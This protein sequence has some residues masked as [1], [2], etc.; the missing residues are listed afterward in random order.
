MEHR[1]VNFK[2]AW[3][4][5]L[6]CSK[7]WIWNDMKFGLIQHTEE[8]RFEVTSIFWEVDGPVRLGWLGGWW[9]ER[10]QP[11]CAH[12]P[13]VS[14]LIKAGCNAKGFPY[15]LHFSLSIY[16][17]VRTRATPE[18]CFDIRRF[19]L[20]GRHGKIWKASVLISA[21]SAQNQVEGSSNSQKM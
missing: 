12:C 3:F 13:M 4:N 7:I 6:M 16:G 17:Y 18:G 5:P 8:L 1:V 20:S 15:L 2:W 19:E 10:K 21:K 14:W 11:T 9:E